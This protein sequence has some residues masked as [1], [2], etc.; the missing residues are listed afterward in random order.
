MSK[1]KDR[2]NPSDREKCYEDRINELSGVMVDVYKLC[3]N[4]S[5]LNVDKVKRFLT[6]DIIK[7]NKKILKECRDDKAINNKQLKTRAKKFRKILKYIEE[8]PTNSG[9]G[10][11]ITELLDILIIQEEMPNVSNLEPLPDVYNT[12]EPL[13]DVPTTI[14]GSKS[15][16][17]LKAQVRGKNKTKGKNGNKT[18][19]KNGNKTKCNRNGK[20]AKSKKGKK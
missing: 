7:V 20:S 8:Y 6:N 18:K 10:D 12:A 1:C 16:R 3:K 15:A 14:P 5:V 4:D 19:G 13:P 17:R 2:A 11:K 9:G